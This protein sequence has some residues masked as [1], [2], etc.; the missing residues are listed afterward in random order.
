MGQVPIC[1]GDSVAKTAFLGRPAS[2]LLIMLRY[3][4]SLT[5]HPI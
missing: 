2:H 3:F 4:L 1:N 5:R